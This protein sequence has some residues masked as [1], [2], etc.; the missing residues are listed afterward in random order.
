MQPAD[1]LE[2]L[3]SQAMDGTEPS[4][5]RETVQL[6]AQKQN[7]VLLLGAA[8]VQSPVSKPGHQTQPPCRC[9]GTCGSRAPCPQVAKDQPRPRAAGCVLGGKAGAARSFSLLLP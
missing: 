7:D 4:T 3:E 6:D 1:S 8:G 9:P 2:A 5:E